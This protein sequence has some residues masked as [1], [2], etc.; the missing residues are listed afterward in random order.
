MTI[1]VTEQKRRKCANISC[2]S[3]IGMLCFIFLRLV[4]P[5]LPIS[6]DCTF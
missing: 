3:T 5:M 6:L 2:T 4:Y 1:I